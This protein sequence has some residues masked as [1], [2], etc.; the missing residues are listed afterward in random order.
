IARVV[1]ADY[2]PVAVCASTASDL[3]WANSSNAD[4]SPY[5]SRTNQINVYLDLSVGNMPPTHTTIDG[6]QTLAGSSLIDMCVY[7]PSWIERSVRIN[8][9]TPGFYWLTFAA[10]GV[11][12]SWGGGL[13]NIRLC[14]QICTGT[15][16]DS[17]PTAWQP[18]GSYKTLFRDTFESPT[19]TA[20][21]SG[22]GYTD[23]NMNQSTG[24]SGTSSS[25][26]PNQAASG[27]AA[28]P[29]NSVPYLVSGSAEGQ[30]SLQLDAVNPSAGNRLISRPFLLVPGY[31]RVDYKYV[32]DVFF[33]SLNTSYCGATPSAANVSAL[34][35]TETGTDRFFGSAQ[36]TGRDTNIV[37]VFMSHAQLA[38]TPIGGGAVGSATS[39]TNPNGTVSTTPT[40]PPNGVSL[41]AYNSSQVN[42]LLDICGYATSWQSRSATIKIVKPAYYWLT[43]SALG[44]GEGLGG[45]VDDVKLTALAS[46]T[47]TSPPSSFVTIPVPDPQPGATIQFSG[48]SIVADPFVTPAP[49]P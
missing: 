33:P 29:Y 21:Y 37:G 43:F 38:S 4:Y 11:N 28:A 6:S 30:Q 19:Y 5:V 26:W 20:N 45:A 49:A 1:Y 36:T 42:P 10:D 46:P 34:T 24:T 32:P 17:F 44:T 9:T 15:L 8:V 3:S 41:T 22:I 14:P 27:W 23:G 47:T 2:N 7:S 12:D 35:G 48:F 31:Y 18:N 40:V 25:G 16:A 39:Y 13:D